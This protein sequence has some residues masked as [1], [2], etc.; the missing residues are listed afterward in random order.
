MRSNSETHL[1]KSTNPYRHN[2]GTS[3][4]IRPSGKSTKNWNRTLVDHGWVMRE[5]PSIWMES[6]WV[7]CP[8]FLDRAAALD[9]G[10][11]RPLEV[12]SKKAELW[13]ARL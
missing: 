13:P 6:L 7:Y 9:R 11:G 8:V 5:P 4:S 12:Q 10:A 1:P 3:G 2:L